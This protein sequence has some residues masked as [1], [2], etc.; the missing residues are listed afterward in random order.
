MRLVL[1]VLLILTSPVALAIEVQ[2]E[3]KT[4]EQA[5]N[6]AFKVAI[7]IEVGVILDRTVKLHTIK[8]FLIVQDTLQHILFY[9]IFILEI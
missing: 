4:L 5:L 1:A 9:I 7:D 6:N 8:Y 3:G 2:G